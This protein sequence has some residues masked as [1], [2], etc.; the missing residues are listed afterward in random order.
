[1]QLVTV[2]T[3]DR[4]LFAAFF[5]SIDIAGESPSTASTCG[6]SI[7]PRKFRAYADSDSMYRRWPSA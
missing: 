4:G 7:C 2:P 1:M 6:L 5:W 3:V